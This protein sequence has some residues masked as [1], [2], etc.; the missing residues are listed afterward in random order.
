MFISSSLFKLYSTAVTPIFQPNPS[1]HQI[2]QAHARLIAAGNGGD[3]HL[4]GQLLAALAQSRSIPF[5]YSLSILHSTQNPSLFAINNLIRCFAKSKS[6]HEAMSLYSFMFKNTYFRPNNYTFPFLLQACGNFKGIVEGTQVQAHVV[7]LGFYNNVYSRNAL[8]HLYFASC[9]SKCAKEVF[10]ES[11]GC[12]DLVT[13]NVMMAGYARMGQI[14]DLE[15]MFDE[16]PEKDIISWSSLI[17]G[18]VQNGYLEQGFDCFKRMRDLGLLPNEAILVMVLSACAQL[19]L[20]EKG[21]LIHSIIDSF[22]CPKTV[23]IWNALVDMYAKCGNIDKARQLFDKMPQ[24]DI[25]S[26]NVMICGFATYGLAMEAIEH[27]EKFLI[28]GRTPENVTFIGVLNACSRAGLVDQGR[29]YFKLMSQKYNIDPEMEHYGCM[30]DLL[31]RAGLIADAIELVEKMPIPPD[32][33]LWVT[34]VAACRTH[35]LVEFG[36]GTGKK[37]IQLD[38]NHHG[39][40]VQLSS[41]FA[42][43]C[44]WEEVLTTRGLNSRKVPGWSLIEAQGKIHQ[45]VAGDREH[46]RTSEIYKMVDRMNTKIVEAGYLPNIS[47]VLH[48]LEEEEK[49]NSIKEHSERLA[50]A[51]GLLITEAGTCIR[52]V[53]NLRVCGDCH[54][55]TK[56]TSKVFQREIIVRDGSRF[57]HFQGGNCSCQDYW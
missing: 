25:S 30:V 44:K 7:K 5:Q 28:E 9:E 43:S 52:I 22:D 20:I 19:G 45:F 3:S 29:H 35:G 41:I 13:W 8:I 33:V 34:I 24:K 39:N 14:D 1:L 18:Y 27:F 17:T 49:I 36:E 32:P 16:M 53:K 56:I 38:P 23:H 10:N 50:I 26:W 51:F 54:E 37:L 46:E 40:Y 11:P 42:K 4:T 6:P 47:S 2:K 31:G 55:M 57:H 15:K 48:D 21:I 12:R